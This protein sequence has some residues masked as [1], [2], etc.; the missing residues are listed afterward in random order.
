MIKKIL[1]ILCSDT[2]SRLVEFLEIFGDDLEGFL[3]IFEAFG[4]DLGKVREFL[5]AK[6]AGRFWEL[7]RLA[8]EH[9]ADKLP[10]L[11]LQAPTKGLGRPPSTPKKTGIHTLKD[12]KPSD[13]GGGDDPHGGGGGG[14]RRR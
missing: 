13:D 8:K 4:G 12:V 7:N 1:A 5:D 2:F 11:L 6:C 10:A 14:L 9:G 3:P